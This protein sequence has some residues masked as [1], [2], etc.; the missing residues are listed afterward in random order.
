MIKLNNG[1]E[2]PQ[3]GAGTWTLKGDIAIN[4]VRL[5]LQAGFRHIDTAQMYEN[6]EEVGTGIA[7][8]GIAREEIF[9]A[10]KVNTVVMRWQNMWQKQEQERRW[11]TTPQQ[12]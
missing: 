8:S 3:I 2:I 11:I 10:T 4:N 12:L 5:A 7:R 1:I 9:L 6:E